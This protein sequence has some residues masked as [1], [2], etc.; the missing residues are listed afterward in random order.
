MCCQF[1]GKEYFA[2]VSRKR[3][4]RKNRRGEGMRLDKTF[5]KIL[6][7][8]GSDIKVFGLKSANE[9]IPVN[10]HMIPLSEES[11]PL[12]SIH[13]AW[14]FERHRQIVLLRHGENPKAT[15]AEDP[16]DFSDRSTVIVDMLSYVTCNDCVEFCVGNRIHLT[17]VDLKIPTRVIQICGKIT[18][19]LF[20]QA[21]LDLP[22][23]SKM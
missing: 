21:F 4:W 9:V 11:L 6:G 19:C 12:I 16:C 7:T 3:V 8:D 14:V 17:D 5:G 22:F 20:P 10:P 18:P 1:L 13:N 15:R 23:R 2:E